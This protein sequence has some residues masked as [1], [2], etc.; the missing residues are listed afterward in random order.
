MPIDR[1]KTFQN[2]PDGPAVGASLISPSDTVDL[3]ELTVGLN[4]ST[5]GQV[6]VSMKDGEVVDLTIGSGRFFPV[7]VSKIWETGTT[8]TGIVALY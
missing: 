1:Y 2:G 7:R 3:I 8:A 5:T 6:R 4:V